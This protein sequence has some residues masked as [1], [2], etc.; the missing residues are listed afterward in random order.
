MIAVIALWLTWNVSA[1]HPQNRQRLIRWA[2]NH[3]GLF[4]QYI[5][6]ANASTAYRAEIKAIDAQPGAIP[7]RLPV[8]G[9]S[10]WLQRSALR[11]QAIDS[12]YIPGVWRNQPEVRQIKDAFPEA[13]III[14]FD[15]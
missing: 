12:I 15:R 8:G 7:R 2:E 5:T 10:G 1:I 9:I 14:G 3:G 13:E 11:D 4:N 6:Y